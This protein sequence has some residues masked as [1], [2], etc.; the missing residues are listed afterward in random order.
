MG[1]TESGFE[2]GGVEVPFGQRSVVTIP[3]LTDL[4][5]ADIALVIHVVVG[6]QRGPVLG[7]HTGTHGSEWQSADITRRLVQSLVSS[8]MS[9]AVL[10]VP[11]A[12]PV[13]FG[14]QTRN[15][16]DESDSPDLNRSFGG[17][18]T[19]IADQL[20]RAIAEHLYSNSDALI[21]FHSGIWGSAMGS[22]TCAR[23]YDD[24][25]LSEASFRM[26]KAFGLGHIRRADLVTKFPGPKSGVGFA[27]QVHGIPGVISEIGGAGFDP[28]TEAAWSDA[29]QDGIVGVMQEMG[30]LAGEPR[31]ADQIL[32]F[33]SVVRVNPANGGF[34]EPI[35]TADGLMKQEVAKGELLGRVWSPYTFEVIEEL[36]S[37]VR[38]LADM[39][40]RD[41]PVRPG[42][43]SY[44][45]VDLDA[46]GSRYIAGGEMP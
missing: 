13:A 17:I 19:W 37:P 44:L 12:N 14:T 42:D 8:E 21:D 27:G 34:V 16:R 30:I 5:D 46:D 18:Q 7:L 24:P 22:V 39:I 45:L 26:A 32:I 1:W 20:A 23:D 9:G 36:R 35:L 40:C 6:D 38:G 43:W 31:V 41:Y 3:V 29:N 15:N 4:D 10:A 28:E 11:V 25:A 2:V 33:D